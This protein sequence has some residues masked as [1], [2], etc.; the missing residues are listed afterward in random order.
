MI[1]C[2]PD[3][4]FDLTQ[5]HEWRVRFYS[6]KVSLELRLKI[7]QESEG[8]IELPDDHPDVVFAVLQSLYGM[9]YDVSSNFVSAAAFHA[10]MY[11]RSE[12]L[13]LPAL[14]DGKNQ[15]LL[16]GKTF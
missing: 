14:K 10:E 6:R 13:G 8:V 12:Y 1:I 11:A 9:E 3:S 5:K 4:V 15:A 2:V 7:I 16:I